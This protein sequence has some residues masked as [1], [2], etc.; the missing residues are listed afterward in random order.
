MNKLDNKMLVDNPIE[1][2]AIGN[3]TT[4]LAYGPDGS[5]TIAIQASRPTDRNLAANWLPAPRE[6]FY[7]VLRL[8]GSLS[9]ATTGQ[10]TPPTVV[11]VAN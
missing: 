4:G 5:L 8:Y 2:Y 6:P 1:R 3:R 10:W 7:M 9:E 11:P